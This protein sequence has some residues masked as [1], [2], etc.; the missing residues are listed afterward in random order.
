[1]AAAPR[2]P[3]YRKKLFWALIAAPFVL[4]FIVFFAFDPLVERIARWQLSKVKGY[5]ITFTHAKLQ[6]TKLNLAMTGFKV[7]KG[8]AGGHQEPILYMERFELSVFWKELIHGN[9]VGRLDIENPKINVITAR[10]KEADQSTELPQ[11]GKE[12]EALL[13]LRAD[14]IQVRRGEFTYIDKTTPDTPKVYLHDL[15]VTVENLST[16]AALARGE[17]TVI[18]MASG[19]QRKGEMSAYITAD[20]LA[21]G[22]WFS[23]QAKAVGLDMR[24]FYDLIASKSGLAL[25]EGT[26]DVFA[27]FD[28]RGDKITGGVRPVLK[29]AK[30]VQ[31][32]KGVDNWL[33]KGLA[34]V[35]LNI[36]SDRVDGRDAVATTIPI[37]G[38]ITGP[39][40]QLWPTIFGVVRNAF[41]AGVTES[42]DR[43]PPPKSEGPENVVKQAVDALSKKK[44][45][46]K[47]QP[48]K[49]E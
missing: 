30:V 16:R 26:L 38:K 17:P 20:P 9:A 36:F 27:E 34:D 42:F 22:L 5:E 31:A 21:K 12:L 1:M 47:A 43:L 37:E 13:P 41:V 44:P 11:L 2:V 25:G 10:S 19:I 48:E 14:R 8:S 29:N 35:A 39:D 24:E 15:E 49:S 18:A 40:I 45:A 32:K 6:P 46:P 28:C 7:V 23:G 3:R 4:F 33:K